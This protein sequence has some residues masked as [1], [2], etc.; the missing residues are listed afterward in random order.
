MLLFLSIGIT[1]I[2]KAESIENR[3][4]PA[5]ALLNGIAN[6]CNE[7]GKAM[8]A[9][10][11]QEKQQAVMTVIGSVFALA[12]R[13]TEEQEKERK[14]REGRSCVY[15]TEKEEQLIDL[16]AHQIVEDA[17]KLEVCRSLAASRGDS[18]HNCEEDESDYA[19]GWV[20]DLVIFAK[21]F[22]SQEH[23]V[24][25]L[26]DQLSILVCRVKDKIVNFLKGEGLGE[27]VED[28]S[29]PKESCA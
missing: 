14:E 24:G 6:T 27:L 9:E 2:G 23:P 13:V 17:I 20:K 28:E 5:A 18:D 16:L 22:W 4:F 3:K 21:K 8:G 1:V 7:V 29:D 19:L 26:K 15:L 12:G 10:T 25:Y 11:P